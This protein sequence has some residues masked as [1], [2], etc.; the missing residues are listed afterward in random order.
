MDGMME[1]YL[2]EFVNYYMSGLA[3]PANL[4]VRNKS[5]AAA[6][7]NLSYVGLFN[8]IMKLATFLINQL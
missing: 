2:M 5:G 1:E 8:P 6:A 7:R 3:D 4:R